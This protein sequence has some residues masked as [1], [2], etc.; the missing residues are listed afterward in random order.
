MNKKTLAR[1]LDMTTEDLDLLLLESEIQSDPELT[2]TISNEEA[3]TVRH[4]VNGTKKAIAASPEKREKSQAL[5]RVP[6]SEIATKTGISEENINGMIDAIWQIQL[7]SIAEEETKLEQFRNAARLATKSDQL[8]QELTAKI[9]RLNSIAQFNPY[10]ILGKDPQQEQQDL[11][12]LTANAL[13][14]ADTILQGG[15]LSA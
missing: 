14:L 5:A 4:V 11:N 10:D 3:K 2:D 15:K 13:S 12:E 9:N 8:K 7:A 6:I 1:E